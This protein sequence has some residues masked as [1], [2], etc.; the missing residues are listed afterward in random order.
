MGHEM[1]ESKSISAAVPDDLGAYAR[2]AEEL[3]RQL[4]EAAD[5]LR[6]ALDAFRC[7]RPEFGSVRYHEFEVQGLA[8]ASGELDHWV[9]LVGVAFAKADQ[10][11]GGHR[12]GDVITVSDKVLAKKTGK[13]AGDWELR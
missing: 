4:L 2:R 3:D 11:H 12:P 1:A 8:Q 13:D 10:R 6:M 9:G 7:S 5:R